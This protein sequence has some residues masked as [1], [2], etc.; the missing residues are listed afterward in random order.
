MNVFH[1]L[2]FNV[3]LGTDSDTSAGSVRPVTFVDEK[4][5]HVNAKLFP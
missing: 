1:Q 4:R 2:S 3:A 5:L